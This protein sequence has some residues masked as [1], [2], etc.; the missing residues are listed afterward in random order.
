M[1]GETPAVRVED[2]LLLSLCRILGESA[3]AL[4][5]ENRRDRGNSR[6]GSVQSLSALRKHLSLS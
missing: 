6:E 2:P 4:V 1:Y 3:T 5:L